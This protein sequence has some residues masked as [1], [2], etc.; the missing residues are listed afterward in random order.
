MTEVSID[1]FLAREL[2]E[3]NLAVI[4]SEIDSI[5][6]VWGQKSAQKMIE[7]TRRGELPEAEMDAIA[8]TNLLDKRNEL[9]QLMLKIGG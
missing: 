9:E 8:L 4:K 1:R 2:V 7:R 6:K 5:L 3:T